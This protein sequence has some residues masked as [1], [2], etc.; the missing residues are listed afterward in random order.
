M[1]G[2]PRLFRMKGLTPI[3]LTRGFLVGTFASLASG[4]KFSAALKHGLLSA[5]IHVGG[6][7][8]NNLVG[9][10]AGFIASGGNKPQI[11][12]GAFF[13]KSDWSD[14]TA[15]AIG[16]AITF[17][18]ENVRLGALTV[19]G[20]RVATHTVLMHELGH[21]PQSGVLGLAYLPT[22]FLSQRLSVVLSRGESTHRY[23]LFERWIHPYPGY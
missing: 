13:Y 11:A 10:T 22:H 7:T 21:I 6:V 5:A 19:L 18:P 14:V 17:N 3:A 1:R 2:S 16:N 9:H 20:S 15:F 8:V 4:E 12:G 23:N